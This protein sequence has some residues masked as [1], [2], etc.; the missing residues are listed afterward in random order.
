MELLDFEKVMAFVAVFLVASI[1]VIAAIMVDLWDG[2]YTAK[3]TKTRIH[4]HKLRVTVEKVTEYWRFILIAFL[5]DAVGMLFQAYF[6]PFLTLLFAVGLIGVE[7]KSMF[8][9]A[10]R[11]KSAA[12]QLP[13]MV[14][15]IIH[16]KDVDAAYELIKKLK[17]DEAEAAQ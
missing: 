17:G 8:E 10:R 5:I 9:H 4:S 1:L 13:E 16:C 2:L 7:V 3:V 6:L 14:S 12:G 11:R 15:D